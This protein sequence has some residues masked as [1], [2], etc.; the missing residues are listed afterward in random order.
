MLKKS[1]GVTQYSKCRVRG[2]MKRLQAGAREFESVV[3]LVRSDW[4]S[5]EA[6]PIRAQQV[7]A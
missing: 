4:L 7:F 3:N 1:F 2:Q 6:R 5:L